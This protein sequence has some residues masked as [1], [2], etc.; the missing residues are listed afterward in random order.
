MGMKKKEKIQQFHL[1]PHAAKEYVNKS[2]HEPHG[3]LSRD[4]KDKHV[5]LVRIAKKQPTPIT[6]GRKLYNIYLEK[7]KQ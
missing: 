4:Y 1:N 3:M 5:S 7:D 2:I 6:T